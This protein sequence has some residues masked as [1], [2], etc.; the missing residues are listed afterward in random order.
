M[1]QYGVK[2]AIIAIEVIGVVVAVAAAVL[3]YLFWRLENG[4]VRFD[5]LKPVA[6]SVFERTLPKDF[7]SAIEDVFLAKDKADGAYRVVIQHIRIADHEQRPVFTLKRAV[8]NFGVRDLLA[9][10]LEPRRI[11][12]DGPTLDI[13]RD[14]S[15]RVRLDYGGGSAGQEN[16]VAFILDSPYFNRTFK[17]AI[18]TNAE[19]RFSD[20]AS[21]RRW[22]AREAGGRLIKENGDYNGRLMAEFAR[23]D[24][25]ASDQVSQKQNAQAV[26]PAPYLRLNAKIDSDVGVL[27]A[28][29]NL[30]DAPLS[31]L[32]AMFYGE[33][34][35]ILTGPVTG[36]ADIEIGRDGGVI[37]SALK[38]E[39]KGGQL[40]LGALVSPVQAIRLETNFDPTRSAFDISA[41]EIAT[42]AAALRLQ[43]VVALIEGDKVAAPLEVRFA[44]KAQDVVVFENDF[45]PEALAFP[46]FDMQGAYNVAA[47]RFA[48]DALEA[49]LFD[50]KATGRFVFERPRPAKGEKAPSPGIDID[51]LIDGPLTRQQILSAWPETLGAAARQFVSER[52]VDAGARNVRAVFNAPAGAMDQGS[53]GEDAL[54]VS[55]DLF[56]AEVIYAPTM[57]HLTGA[58][59]AAILK[60]NSFFI[61]GVTGRVGA[62]AISA[63]E[64]AIPVMRPKGEE[65]YFRF[66]ADGDAGDILGILDAEP[67]A[68]LKTTGL[69][70]SAFAG[71]ASVRVEIM[72]PNQT[73]TPRDSYRFDGQGTFKNLSVDGVLASADLTDGV[74]DITLKTDQMRI[75]AKAAF[76]GAPIELD[77]R[78]KFYGSGD[79]LSARIAGTVNSSTG[80]LFGVPTRQVLRGD[81]EF[82]ADVKGDIGAFNEIS[83]RTDFTNSVL[84]ADP[85][86]WMKPKGQSAQGRVLVKNKD[87]R[88]I[89][90]DLTIN[91]AGIDVKGNFSLSAAG[92]LEQASFDKLF[93]QNAVDVALEVTPAHNEAL[94]IMLSGSYLNAR[95]I[96]DVFFDNAAA[97]RADQA[98]KGAPLIDWGNG[99]HFISRLD[100]LEL[101]NRVLY[102]DAHIDF[103]RNEKEITKFDLSARSEN[104]GP[105]SMGLA[106]IDGAGGADQAIEARTDDVGA[107]L[108][109]FFDMKSVIGGQGVVNLF[110]RNHHHGDDHV[111]ND[112]VGNDKVGNGQVATQTAHTHGEDEVPHATPEFTGVLEAR[113]MR[114]VGA[115]LL[116]RIFS[117]GSLIGL[118]DLL[119]GEGIEVSQGFA[120]FSF[121]DNVLMLKDLNAAGPSVGLS[122]DGRVAS[123]AYGGVDL[124]GA[125]API[126]QVNS[127]LGKTPV[128]GDLFVNREGEGVVALSY[129][130]SGDPAALKVSVNPLSALTPGFLRRIFEP[131]VDEPSLFHAAPQAAASDNAPDQDNLEESGSDP[132]GAG[133]ELDSAI[134][135]R[136]P[137]QGQQVQ[138][139]Q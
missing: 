48:I 112:K 105:L 124:R 131:P 11:A 75:T 7:D 94:G 62:V 59:G 107:F 139:A 45:F 132:N 43:G 27:K 26:N 136:K 77:W 96:V 19:I 80:D 42:D 30:Q 24:G 83:L 65:A 87:G 117:A 15:R 81:V 119:S 118:S 37:A 4:P 71:D 35:V 31:D 99:L 101:R 16:P 25:D 97:Q 39:M 6:I 46:S 113:D 18:I 32:L 50:A 100:T 114:I 13:V 102:K 41:L 126:Y 2:L 91:G 109:G 60:A 138:Q 58:G 57:R 90:E 40:A 104:G 20:E 88:T 63:G 38:G 22:A 54:A 1:K 78:Q 17:S 110:I 5:F 68:V 73:H 123:E 8:L 10:R 103:W 108:S 9:L 52:I 133:Q 53:L 86:Y 111:H 82:E 70:P 120:R 66:T 51:V 93:L 49:S 121:H 129:A 95:P 89:V 106:L 36:T 21:G 116:A 74:G 69:E 76:S 135:D 3:G 125:V 56:D 33:R 12:L 134:I 14:Q 23:E 122:A 98:D 67:L 72:R 64:V 85:F 29:L 127:F 130:L 79:K 44:V 55:F 61:R 47:R 28:G 115:P 128:I 34:A 137:P 84:M 92:Q